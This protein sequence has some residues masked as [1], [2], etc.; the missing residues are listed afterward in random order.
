MLNQIEKRLLLSE[1]FYRT[2]SVNTEQVG[3]IALA[4]QADSIFAMPV[5]PD[6]PDRKKQPN[7]SLNPR[8]SG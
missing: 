1:Q 2:G 3:V 4:D 5:V 8:I 6:S 7:F